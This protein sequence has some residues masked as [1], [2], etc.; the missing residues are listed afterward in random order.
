MPTVMRADYLSGLRCLLRLEISTRAAWRAVE[1]SHC[2]VVAGAS[3]G[4]GAAYAFGMLC[5]LKTAMRAA[6]WLQE[7]AHRSQAYQ[8]QHTYMLCTAPAHEKGE[9]Q[10]NRF[11]QH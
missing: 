7:H 8:A 1:S 10:A 9:R 6:E 4:D 3:Y 2:H 11:S 5:M